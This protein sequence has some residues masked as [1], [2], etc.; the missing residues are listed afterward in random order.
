MEEIY[1]KFQEFKSLFDEIFNTTKNI[2]AK[3]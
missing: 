1:S 2:R 3:R